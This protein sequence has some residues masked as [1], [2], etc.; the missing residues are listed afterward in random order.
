M[1]KVG[2]VRIAYD[3]K[4]LSGHSVRRWHRGV[5]RG[6]GDGGSN[7]ALGED[8]ALGRWG[9]GCLA[10]DSQQREL[11]IGGWSLLAKD[12]IPGEG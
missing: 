10:G 9:G 8:N 4:R 6:V 11:E 2:A 3:N 5:K 12:T 7:N 1:H